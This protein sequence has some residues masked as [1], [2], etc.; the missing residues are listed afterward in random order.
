[1]PH[2]GFADPIKNDRTRF[3]SNIPISVLAEHVTRAIE[4]SDV[5]STPPVAGTT[6]GATITKSSRPLIEPPL[7]VGAQGKLD[8][9]RD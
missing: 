1:M 8:S 2:K 3:R 9:Q 6:N 7:R 5:S 4:A